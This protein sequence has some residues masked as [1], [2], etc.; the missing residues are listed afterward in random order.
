MLKPLKDLPRGEFVKLN[1]KAK[2]VWMK[3]SYLPTSKKYE[4]MDPED[5]NGFKYVSG[6]KP[7]VYGFTY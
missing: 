6:D 7:V 1:E 5:I 3:G 2:K 4:L